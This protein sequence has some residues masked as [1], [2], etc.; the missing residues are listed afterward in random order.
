[1][2]F[3]AEVSGGPEQGSLYCSN[4]YLILFIDVNR[5]LMLPLLNFPTPKNVHCI[6]RR[7]GQCVHTHCERVLRSTVKESGVF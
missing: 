7:N 1:M 5:R 6:K 2:S 3:T 4:L